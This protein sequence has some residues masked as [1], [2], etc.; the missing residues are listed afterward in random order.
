M[1][2]PIMQW[3]RPFTA[4]VTVAVSGHNIGLGFGS[5]KELRARAAHLA[6]AIRAAASR[7]T[8]PSNPLEQLVEQAR[9]VLPQS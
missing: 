7:T 6:L 8:Q 9:D 3:P 2:L 4:H 5:R 1:R